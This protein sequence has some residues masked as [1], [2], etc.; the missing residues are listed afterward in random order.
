MIDFVLGMFFG[1]AIGFMIAAV[2]VQARD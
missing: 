2:L 1:A